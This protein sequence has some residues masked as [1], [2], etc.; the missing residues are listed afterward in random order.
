MY[1]FVFISENFQTGRES[2]GEQLPQS[3]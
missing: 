3:F 1:S 2:N